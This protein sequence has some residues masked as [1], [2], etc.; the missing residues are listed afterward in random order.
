MNEDQNVEPQD[1]PVAN[2]TPQ[3]PPPPVVTPPKVSG[4]I[5]SDKDARTWGMLCHLLAIFLGWLGPLICWLVKKDEYDF[6]DDQGKEALNFQIT[7]FIAMIISAILIF[8][9]I[10][11][12]MIWAVAICSLIFCIIGAMKANNGERYRYPICIRFIK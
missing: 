9:L 5:E 11:I 3:S 2:E 12:L 8:I 7:V 6:V 1:G 10:G 4:E